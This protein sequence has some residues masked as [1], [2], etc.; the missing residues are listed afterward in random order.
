MVLSWLKQAM[1]ACLL[2]CA[3][4]ALH[5]F[6]DSFFDVCRHTNFMRESCRMDVVEHEKEYII[7]VDIPG[8]SK[9]DI[10]LSY[11][12]NTLVIAM[13][14]DKVHNENEEKFLHRE[15]TVKA[16]TRAIRLDNP[17]FEKAKAK[18]EDG[19][20]TIKVPREKSRENYKKIKID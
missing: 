10:D 18:L 5:A 8:V 2:F 14:S 3:C 17:R 16:F 9:S 12:D 13:S 7:E 6:D 1:C 15:R 11:S 19:V 20:L 4:S